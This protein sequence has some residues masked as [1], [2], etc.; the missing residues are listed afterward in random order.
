MQANR[1][2]AGHDLGK[3][4]E[5]HGK[6]HY[7]GALGVFARQGGPALA[8][9]DPAP[10]LPRPADIGVGPTVFAVAGEAGGGV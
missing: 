2:A 9:L 5:V 6:Q 1:R 8:C 10:F 4:V 7:G 3:R